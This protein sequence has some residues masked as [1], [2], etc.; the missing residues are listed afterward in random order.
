MF[1]NKIPDKKPEYPTDIFSW[2]NSLENMANEAITR[3]V[4]ASIKKGLIENEKDLT[5]TFVR[6]KYFGNKMLVD[7]L[8]L[9]DG[10]GKEHFTNT[11][12]LNDLMNTEIYMHTYTL[13]E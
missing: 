9:P 12:N 2:K 1:C 11:L 4:L 3:F 10:Y 8:L 5:V 6:N 13:R 7:T